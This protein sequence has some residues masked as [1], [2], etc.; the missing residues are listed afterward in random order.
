MTAEEPVLEGIVDS[1]RAVT[2][3]FFPQRE[4]MIEAR[5]VNDSFLSGG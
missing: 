1:S 5:R 4:I 3:S 2:R